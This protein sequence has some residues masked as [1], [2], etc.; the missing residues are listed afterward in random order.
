MAVIAAGAGKRCIVP[1]GSL[2][3]PKLDFLPMKLRCGKRMVYTRPPPDTILTRLRCTHT[4]NEETPAV[5]TEAV[6]YLEEN[7]KSLPIKLGGD[8]Q[9]QQEGL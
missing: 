3:A 5:Q 4:R 7:V 2:P 8:T 6:V 1:P 9:K